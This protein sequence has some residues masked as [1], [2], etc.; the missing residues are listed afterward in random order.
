MLCDTDEGVAV[1]VAREGSI[2]GEGMG[3]SVGN[4]VG[5]AVSVGG[6]RVFVGIAACVSA[7]IVSAAANAVRLI[8]S[9]LV[10]ASVGFAL[11]ALNKRL[12]IAILAQ[13]YL[14]IL[15]SLSIIGL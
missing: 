5:L 1:S 9:A 6:Q 10:D 2:V 8:S 13:K 7:T 14:F 15:E 12:N 3:V 4:G 11:H